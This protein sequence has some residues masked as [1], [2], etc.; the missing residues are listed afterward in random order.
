MR[1]ERRFPH[2]ALGLSADTE[3]PQQPEQSRPPVLLNGMRTVFS[4][5]VPLYPLDLERRPEDP[6]GEAE[7]RPDGRRS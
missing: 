5:R 1:Q 2:W 4:E 6:A 3:A 7:G